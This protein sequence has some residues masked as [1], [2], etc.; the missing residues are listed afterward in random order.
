[1]IDLLR[2]LDLFEGIDDE[3][4]E[5]FAAR[6][7][8]L[9]LDVGQPLV[10][11]GERFDRFWVI[12]EG[13]VE[14]TRCINGTDLLLGERGAPTYAGASNILT[15]DPAFA[16]GRASTAARALTWDLE[17]FRDFLRVHPGAM[18]TAVRLIGPVA[19]AAESVVRQQEKLAALGTLSAGLAHEL[20]NPAAAARR[21]AGEL[22]VALTT[23]QDSIRKF[24]SSGVERE[25][26]AAL[27]A[28]QRQALDQAA[29]SGEPESAVAFADREE[30]LAARLDEAGADGWRL[31]EPLARARIDQAWLD[32]VAAAAGPAN[33]AAIEWVAASV[34]SHAL[35]AELHESTA[36]ISRLVG[37]VKDYTYM[38]RA[39]IEE[40]DIH[41]G[42]ESTLT[43]LGH[44]LKHGHVAIQRAYGDGLPRVTVHGSELNQV[45]T[46]LLVNALDAIDGEGVISISTSR[47]P[48][49]IA[50]EIADDGPGIPEELRSRIFE[51]F[52][53]TKPV[54][55]GTGLGLDIARRIVL[56]HRGEISLRS[57]RDGT[58]FV[59][60]LPVAPSP[61]VEA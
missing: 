21:T 46:N 35:V 54:G 6:A 57:G 61:A 15:G 34:A 24:V 50:V 59:V 22:D 5:A 11:E 10:V 45:W 14:W 4:L 18:R 28:L 60:T 52:F 9:R 20:N 27:V 39:S 38:D 25:Q 36:R 43:M 12:A 26:A 23:I 17:P 2:T 41:D 3:L 16:T 30:R 19:Q 47:A 49:G 33:V 58:A 13:R 55:S 37:A 40:V 32:A 53:T 51:P 31:A 1:M 48:A 8:E 7:T 56:G 29:E 42:I 44:R